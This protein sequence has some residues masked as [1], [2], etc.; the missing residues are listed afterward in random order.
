MIPAARAEPRIRRTLVNPAFQEK[1]ADPNF[2]EARRGLASW[3]LH[4][5]KNCRRLLSGQVGLADEKELS[6]VETLDVGL[7]QRVLLLRCGEERFLVGT[8][9]AGVQAITRVGDGFQDGVSTDR[10]VEKLWS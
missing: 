6:I 10:M 5:L 3:L 2:A 8:G 9:P 4:Q 7:R 1:S